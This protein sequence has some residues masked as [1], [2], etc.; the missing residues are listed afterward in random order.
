MDIPFYLPEEATKQLEEAEENASDYDK[1]FL[2]QLIQGYKWQ[3]YVLQ[4]I[5]SRGHWG[6]V[7]PLRV[8]P[9]RSQAAQYTDKFDIKVGSGPRPRKSWSVEIDVKART[10]TFKSPAS[11]PFKSIIIEPVDRF[12]KRES[13]PDYWCMVSQNNGE[14]IFIP[15]KN[16]KEWKIEIMAGRKYRTA[17]K[18]EFLSLG[19]FLEELDGLA[20]P[21]QNQKAAKGKKAKTKGKAKV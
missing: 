2:K 19:Q 9:E 16:K 1:R 10:R 12:D 17:P 20:A 4:A 15:S 13:Y 14:M 21:K 18:K 5:Q 8:R 11:F 7:H 6:T 3:V